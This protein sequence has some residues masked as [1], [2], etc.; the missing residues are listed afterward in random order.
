MLVYGVEIISDAVLKKKQT[1]TI[2]VRMT[3]NS[4]VTVT[5]NVVVKSDILCERLQSVLFNASFLFV[6]RHHQVQ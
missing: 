2:T 3:L 1:N 5:A 6:S 4:P